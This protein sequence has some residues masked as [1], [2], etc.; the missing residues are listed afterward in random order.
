MTAKR[1]SVLCVA[2][3]RALMERILAAVQKGF[4]VSKSDL[5]RRALEEYLRRAGL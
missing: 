1:G 3:D 5:V 4:A 2:V